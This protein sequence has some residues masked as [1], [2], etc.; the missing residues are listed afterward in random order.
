M[1]KAAACIQIRARFPVSVS[2]SVVSV[3]EGVVAKVVMNAA[4]DSPCE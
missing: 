3:A 4:A 2:V 1:T